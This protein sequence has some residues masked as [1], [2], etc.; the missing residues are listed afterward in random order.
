MSRGSQQQPDLNELRSSLVQSL[1]DVIGV[2]PEGLLEDAL[3]DGRVFVALVNMTR[4]ALSQPQ[5]RMRYGASPIQKKIAA[6]ESIEFFLSLCREL[7]FRTHELFFEAD[8]LV[9]SHLVRCASPH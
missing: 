2:A 6:S 9:R 4:R 8:V 1:T 3:V 5:L 7:G